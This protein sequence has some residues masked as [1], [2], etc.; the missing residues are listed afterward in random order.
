MWADW[1]NT[2]DRHFYIEEVA[3]TKT[4]QYILPKRWIIINKKVC[5]EGHPVYLSKHVSHAERV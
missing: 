2:P 5:A 1:E 4:G 3:C